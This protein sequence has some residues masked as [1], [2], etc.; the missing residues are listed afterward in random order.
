MDPMCACTCARAAYV[1]ARL[2]KSA[3]PEFLPAS[4]GWELMAFSLKAIIKTVKNFY[5]PG[6]EALP[7]VFLFAFASG[8]GIGPGF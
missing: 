3:D 7:P 1:R 2:R 4:S 6:A 8:I 5:A